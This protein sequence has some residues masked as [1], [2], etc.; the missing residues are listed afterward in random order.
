[1]WLIII[2]GIL[3]ITFLIIVYRS[4]AKQYYGKIKDISRDD[5]MKEEK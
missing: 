1:M 5:W 4:W 3:V 2:C